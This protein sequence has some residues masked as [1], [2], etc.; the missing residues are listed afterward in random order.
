[1]NTNQIY[2]AIKQSS[3]S[4]LAGSLLLTVNSA[5]AEIKPAVVYDVAGKFDKSFN[6][7]VF[8]NGVQKFKA[9]TGIRV[10]EVEP[11]NDA[12][13]EQSLKSLQSEAMVR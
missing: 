6:E 9:D 12:Q 10:T 3:I 7:A 1:M 2:R 4:L 13:K 11:T 5:F 8:R